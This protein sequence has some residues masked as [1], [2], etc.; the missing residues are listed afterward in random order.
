M[1][2]TT[3]L[4]LSDTI[5]DTLMPSGAV[6]YAAKP[7]SFIVGADGQLYKCSVAFEEEMNQVGKLQHDGTMELDLDKMALWTIGGEEQDVG[8]QNCYF[9]PA[10]QGNHCPLYRMRTKKRPCPHE[11]RKLKQVLNLLC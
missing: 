9:R 6:C 10:C 2:C 3:R 8:C 11:K 7:N 5:A 4:K 1:R